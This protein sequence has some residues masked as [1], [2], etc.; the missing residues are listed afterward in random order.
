[1]VLQYLDLNKKS[2]LNKK[3]FTGKN[4]NHFYDNKDKYSDKTIITFFED[5][6][7]NDVDFYKST[8]DVVCSYCGDTFSCKLIHLLKLK[9]L[10]K[11]TY[12][13]SCCPKEN[14]KLANKRFCIQEQTRCLK[15]LEESGTE[16]Q[17]LT[18]SMGTHQIELS[19]SS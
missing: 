6:Y 17:R 9:K 8:I 13:N 7:K 4:I 15:R 3:N 18:F 12:M 16:R 11:F 1:M 5:F 2:E 14:C 10:N 19:R